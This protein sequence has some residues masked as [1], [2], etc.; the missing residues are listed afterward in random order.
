MMTEKIF[1]SYGF[2]AVKKEMKKLA[3]FNENQPAG[4]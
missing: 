4:K 1:C 3:K 2:T